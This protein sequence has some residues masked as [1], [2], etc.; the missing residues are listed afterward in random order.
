MMLLGR[1]DDL[2]RDVDKELD[3]Q[4]AEQNL[5]L[6][7]EPVEPVD[8]SDSQ[9]ERRSG[10]M[11]DRRSSLYS[12]RR[13][14]DRRRA[15]RSSAD[16]NG[17]SGSRSSV[18]PMNI[19]LREMGTLTLLSH[20]EELTLAQQ[21]EAG[22]LRVQNAVMKT[23]LALPALIE[24]IRGLD[25]NS[26]M[27]TQIISGITENTPEILD[28][29]GSE[30]LDRV[31]RAI[32]LDERRK[33]LL[34]EYLTYEMGSEKAVRL[35]AE[36]L[37]LGEQISVLFRDKMICAE[38]IKAI[39][40]GLEELSRRFRKVF[41]EVMSNRI[42]DKDEGEADITPELIE[43]QVNRQM[44]EESGVDERLL[45]EILKEVDGG[46]EVFKTAKES[47]VRANLRLV[48]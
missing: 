1:E 25:R 45:R 36:I 2:V 27:I 20:E 5:L 7:E 33:K 18:D 6:V 13:K 12:D 9:F 17:D 26:D 43:A 3:D 29:E 24:I 28:R 42:Q 22:K 19:Y 31:N 11:N 4:D 23:P 44:L 46:W 40:N 48:I 16:S 34:S 35:F 32:E 14:R 39:A 15:S 38:C 30:F 21:M 8:F 37:S 47:F 10:R 41:V